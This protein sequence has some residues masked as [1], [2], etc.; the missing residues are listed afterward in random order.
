MNKFFNLTNQQKNVWNSEMFYSGTNINSIGGYLLIREKIN[1]DLLEKTANIYV[2]NNEV[3]RYHF[4]LNDG[5]PVQT[6]Q[7]YEPFKMKVISLKNL[8]ELAKLTTEFV[9]KPFKV[10]NSNLYKFLLFKLPDGTGGIIP[11]FHHLIADAW[12]LSLFISEFV[13]IYSNLLKGNNEFSPYPDY[14]EYIV[15]SKEYRES[16]KFTKDKE[17]WSSVFNCNP[18]LTY[19]SNKREITNSNCN[20]KICSFE[21]EFYNKI[22]EYCKNHKCSAYTFFMAVFSIYL[23]KINSS[24]SAML[25]TPV[26]NRSNF[27]EKNTSGMFVSTVPFKID[28][29]SSS[30]FNTFLNKVLLNQ[31]SIFRHQ[32]YPYSELLQDIKSKYNINENLYDFVL[33]YQNARDNRASSDLDYESTWEPISNIAESIEAHFYDMD[34]HGSSNIYYY[35][36]TEKFSEKDIELLHNRIINICSQALDNP[37]IKDMAVV[38]K[39]DLSVLASF[40]DT[41]FKYNKRHTL[42]DIFEKQVKSFPDKKAVIFKDKYITYKELDEK[43][44]S[45]ANYLLSKNITKSDVI[46]IMFKRSLDIITSIWGVLKTGAS[47]ILIDHNLPTDRINYML[48]SSNAKLVITNLYI[49]YESVDLKDID[50]LNTILPK[51]DSSNDDRFCIIYTSGSTGTPKGVELKRLGIIN[52]VNSF[53]ELLKTS[54]CSNFLST[55]AVSFDMFIVENFISILD[56][57]TVILADEDEQKIPAFTSKLI[58]DNNVDFI[59]STPSKIKLLLEE[60][61]CLKNVKVIQLGGEVFKYALYKKLREHT[62]ADIHNGYGPSECTACAT[63]KLVTNENINI[64]K[65]YLNTKVYIMN[66]DDNILPIGISGEIVIKG[67]GVGKGYI[68]K[69]DF[70]G[71]YHT[72][73]MGMISNSGEL[74]YLGRSDN[75]IKLHGLRIELDEI[76]NKIMQIDGIINAVSVIKKVN[77]MDCICSYIQADVSI[78]ENTIKDNL[79]KVLPKYMLPSHIMQLD[80][81]SITTNGKID[82]KSL[83]EISVKETEF[84]ECITQMEKS[85]EKIWKNIFNQNKI[86]A[87]ISFFDLGADSLASIRL[88]SE[89]YSKLNLKIDIKDIYTYPTITS[90]SSF[91]ETLGEQKDISIKKHKE[92]SSYPISSAQRR[93]FYTTNMEE[94]SLAYN[95]PFGI[96]FKSKPNITKLESALS[97][98]INMHDAFKTYF[99]LE[100]GDV[101]QKTVNNIDFHLD[102]K[103]YKNEDFIK[104]FDLSKAPL[105]H[106]E[107]N[108]YDGKYLLQLD[109]HHIICDGVS[110]NIFANEL[111]NLYNGIQ[112][113]PS[114]IDYIDYA[115]S[116]HIKEED[117]EYW[118]SQFSNGVPLLNMPTEFE[119]TNIKSYEGSNLYKNLQSSKITELCKNLNITPYMFLL[120]CFYVLLYKYTMQND[121]IIGTPIVGR[122]N[123]KLNNIIGMFVNTLPLKQ[124][125]QPSNKFSE[126]LL[127]VK[128]NCLNSYNHQTY[129]FDELVKVLNVQ[130]DP[131]RNP[132]FDVMFTYESG[133]MPTFKIDNEDVEYLIP[134]NNTSK[135][136]FSLEVTPSEDDFSLRLEYCSKLYSKNFM[137][138]FLD[139]Y[140][141]IID[142]VIDNLDIQISKINMLS[143]V[144]DIYPKLDYPK[145]SRIIDLFEKQVSLTPDKIALVFGNEKYTYKE[146][147]VKVNKLANHLKNCGENKIIGIMMN[148]S[149]EL[150]ISILAT[151]KSG[152]GYLPIDPTYPTDR[153]NYIIEDSHVNLI[154]TEKQYANWVNIPTVLVDDKNSYDKYKKFD[155]NQT[156]DDIAYLIYT[157]GSTGKPK[158][159]II[160]Q[161]SVINFIYGTCE[162]I[163]LKDKTI[164]NI[165]TMCFDIFVLESLLPLCTGMKVVMAS[166]EEQNNPILLNQLCLKNGVQVIQTTPSKFKFLMTDNLEYLKNLEVISLIGEPFPIDLLKNIKSITNSRVYN[167]YGPT[168]TTV[169]STLK[170]LTNT[171]KITIGKPLA[172]TRVLVLDNDLNPVPYNVP[173]TLYIGGDGV[174]LGYLNRPE[175]T[176]EKFI[177]YNGE[178]IY[179][180][181]DLA[182]F[183]PNGELACLG[184]TDFQVKVRGLR[185]ELGEIEKA[186]CS[187]RGVKDSVVTVKNIDGREILCG[188][189]VADARVSLSTLK[190]SLSK[191]LPNY[192]IPSYLLQ[193]DTFKYTPNGKIDRKDLPDPVFESK[194]IIAPKTDLETKILNIWRSILSINE[195]ST[196]DNFFDIGGDSL[197]A[198]KMQIELMKE[199]LNI[200]YGDIFKNNTIISLA[201]FLEKDK[202]SNDMPIYSK[203]DFKNVSKLLKKNSTFKRL[204]LKQKDLNNVLLVGATGFLGIHVL[205]ELLKI[206][207]IK[208]YCLVRNDPSTS[209]EH[210]LK[211]KFK[212]YFGSDLS[213]LFGTRLFVISGNV[214][215]SNFDISTET[216]EL[217]GKEVSSVVNCAASVKHYGNYKD[218]EIINVNAVKNLVA[219]CGKYGKEFYQTSTISVSGNTMTSLPNSYNPKK[220]IY[221]G[222]NKLFIGQKLD[223]VY[224]RSKFEAEKFVLEE[225]S[226]HK[227]K[228]IILRIGNLTHRYSDGKFQDNSLDN[229]FLNRLKAF[230]YLKELPESMTKNYIEFSPVDK[231]AESIVVCMKYYTDPMSVLHLYNSNHLYIDK[232][233]EILRKLGF[234]I[235][236]VSDN[237]FKEHLNSK[238]FNSSNSDTVSVLLNDMDNNKNLIYKTNLQITNKFT[239]KFLDKADFSWPEITKDYIEKILKNLRG[240]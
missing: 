112:V 154:L 125:V 56:G 96:L 227:L 19:I 212:Y 28:I 181:G 95:T 176:A 219:F 13:D 146:L 79:S 215:S 190:K 142:T 182:K 105:I 115:V 74:I 161:S 221:F 134:E 194:E 111:C 200:N 67:D 131:S 185:I 32:K 235:D 218:F 11:V 41:D 37:C 155:T 106:V 49:N 38:C 69:Y 225:I 179:N 206:D 119:R 191:K 72:G 163:D 135:F 228:G 141:N 65:P 220:K 223:N 89:I 231:I 139:C 26:L 63:N 186:I 189:F 120:S 62:K 76:T 144:P 60:P 21:P 239:L 157:S 16:N 177:N 101:V 51:V 88:V 15:S 35:Y 93:I 216:Y 91:L 40:N 129:P 18:D 168:E 82:T 217:L 70:N 5:N 173:G 160:K 61:D 208:I 71:I 210:K 98:I 188:Y 1:L 45:I 152:A 99:V 224:V 20:R 78:D 229:A 175:L 143:E 85:L 97:Q 17:Y 84:V 34:D 12:S 104:P 232:F 108:H 169:G 47:Y 150:I 203:K 205:A 80:N 240:E 162:D 109:I 193:L 92:Q 236:V 64:G 10:I 54:N 187:Y 145:D 39:D 46:G 137:E 202:D 123:P 24:S 116:E 30:D 59:V 151:L 44:N 238:L 94:G 33:S 184:R 48:N 156:S 180:S 165:T 77:N 27:R 159:V 57:K 126:F 196:D 118:I 117:K 214:T 174:S 75:Q 83:P 167:M 158:G 133:G 124:N 211:N 149:S 100:N 29:D 68:N 22:L 81:F 2:Q 36:Q 233:I 42:V 198:L 138:T 204:K 121:I 23:A 6:L 31:T 197:Y 148:R 234:T 170:D 130:R 90:L 58:K 87:N 127:A 25:G 7:D 153:I 172:N 207:H 192:M 136:D 201:E 164:V 183:L 3:I 114:N 53:R 107:L 50:N 132:M 222:E 55:S 195:I 178:L 4:N 14:S 8:K 73:D 43:S 122:S 230:M 110:I 9:A 52:L 113:K 166:N 102:I 213:N 171:N 237:V 103:N 209:A 226:N 66:K 147:E 128:G 140:I 199:N 86:S